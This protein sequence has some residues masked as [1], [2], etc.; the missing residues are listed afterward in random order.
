MRSED[1]ILR[2]RAEAQTVAL[3]CKLQQFHEVQWMP[4]CELRDL[5]AATET[6][7]HDGRAQSDAAH[8]RQKVMLA[9][10]HRNVVLIF[11]E[12]ERARHAATSRSEFVQL[13]SHLSEQVLL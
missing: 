8:R 7:G 11:F 12:S 3:H 4:V 9:N 13:D 2:H 6:V 1:F 10:L 5:L